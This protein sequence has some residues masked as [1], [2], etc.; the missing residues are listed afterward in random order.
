MFQD[1]AQISAHLHPPTQEASS[2]NLKSCLMT[3]GVQM[4]S[5]FHY[6]YFLCVF[7]FCHQPMMFS[8]IRTLFQ[9]LCLALNGRKMDEIW[10]MTSESPQVY[11]WWT[12]L[13]FKTKLYKQ[14]VMW[15]QNTENLRLIR[16]SDIWAGTKGQGKF[17][18]EEEWVSWGN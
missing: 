13:I 5:V 17:Q 14:R 16:R 8:I 4:L 15:A 6:N 9:V 12:H 11:S 1:L 18:G 2:G 10:S 3:A 7:I